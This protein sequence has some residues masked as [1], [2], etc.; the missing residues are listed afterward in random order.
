M[1][2]AVKPYHKNLYPRGGI[3]V[4]G[5]TV[6]GW[7]QQV[8]EMGLALEGMDIYPIAGREA[9]TIWGCLL[10]P[11]EAVWPADTGSNVYCQ[12]LQDILFLPENSQLYPQ[13][14]VEELNRTLKGKRH[15]FHPETGWIELPAPILWEELLVLP[16]EVHRLVIPPEPSVFIPSRLNAFYKHSLPFEDVLANMDSEL[17]A[18]HTSDTRPLSVWEKI[19]L[20]FLRLF[21][22]GDK[23]PPGLKELEERNNREI[24]KLLDLFKKDPREALKYAVP[25]NNDGVSRGLS[26]PSAYRFSRFWESLSLLGSWLGAM[27][28][29]VSG[30]GISSSGA[31]GG[32]VL[33]GKR[34][35][36]RLNQEYRNAAY[37]LMKNKEYQQAAFVYL[38]L[39]KDYASGAE[40]LEKGGFYAEA[41]SVY[42]K[43]ANNKNR[44]AECFEK[45]QLPLEAIELYKEMLR[46]EKVGDLYLSIGKRKEAR[47]YFEKVIGLYVHNHQYVKA[48]AIHRDKLDEPAEAQSLL[49][50]GWKNGSDGVNCLTWYFALVPDARRLEQE[51]QN[52]YR[53]ETTEKNREKFLQVLKHQ[54]DRYET[55]QD[56]V[57]DIAYEIVAARIGEDPF[58]ASELQAFNKKDKR[59]L[60]DILLYRQRAR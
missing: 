41:A 13:L 5:N 49:L 59:L 39:L 60:K 6:T 37:T 17:F 57:R 22:S 58:I 48:A 27:G 45:G 11:R 2:L 24:H 14:S 52:I 20:R 28:G 1:Q 12:C 51:I 26:I 42:L 35:I 29:S 16:G 36:D 44:A 18:E 4:R 54:F 43:Y 21:R 56:T 19:K 9:N 30:S 34:Y 38:K 8:Q 46:D 53:R 10:A 40:A 15:L 32:S 25:I 50:Q 31:A 3:L 33:L 23:Q 55:I 7:L 47:P